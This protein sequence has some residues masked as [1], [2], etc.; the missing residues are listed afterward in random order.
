M[1]KVLL[2]S[3]WRNMYYKDIQVKI[4]SKIDATI[5]V[6]QTDEETKIVKDC[7]NI[8]YMVTPLTSI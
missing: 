1:G 5:F 7:Q 4:D 3:L 2:S 8:L 6:N